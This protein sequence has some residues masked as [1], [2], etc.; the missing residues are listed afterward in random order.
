V[1]ASALAA[2]GMQAASGVT[3]NPRGMGQV[4]LFPYYTASGCFASDY[5]ELL[6]AH[7]R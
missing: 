6:H 3:L 5:R 4:L 2:C 7:C 1:L